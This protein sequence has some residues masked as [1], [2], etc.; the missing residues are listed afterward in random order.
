[1][2]QCPDCGAS[3]VLRDGK[4]GK[5]YGCASYPT[6]TKTLPL[7]A[8]TIPANA[9]TQAATKKALDTFLSSHNMTKT[10]GKLW[11]QDNLGINAEDAN[12]AFF[13]DKQCEMVMAYLKVEDS[14]DSI[15]T[16]MAAAFRNAK[17]RK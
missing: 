11:L 16:E 1:M 3:M 9:K 5:F 2:M 12:V 15:G 17:R 10:Q 7:G 4:F 13:S 14:I 8:A 6:C